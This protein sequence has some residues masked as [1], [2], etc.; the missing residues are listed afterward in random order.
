MTDQGSHFKLKA[1]QH[2]P[3]CP[4]HRFNADERVSIFIKTRTTLVN[5]RCPEGGRSWPGLD[6]SSCNTAI[7]VRPPTLLLEG[8][9]ILVFLPLLPRSCS[10]RFVCLPPDVTS[11]DFSDCLNGRLVER[12]TAAEE[13]DT[14]TGERKTKPSV[15]LTSTVRQKQFHGFNDKK[16]CANTQNIQVFV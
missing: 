12:P 8:D 7:S 3:R 6:G 14:F 10:G 9:L 2:N 4:F 15:S 13:C 11:R 5:W 1:S 16:S